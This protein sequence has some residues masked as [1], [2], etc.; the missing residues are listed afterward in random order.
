L[1]LQAWKTAERR[2]AAA[3]GGQRHIRFDRTESACDVDHDLLSVECKY[4]KRLPTLVKAAM[5]QAERYSDGAKI[6]AAVLFERGQRGGFVVLRLADFAE[7]F[8]EFR[9]LHVTEEIP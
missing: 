4:R 8:G 3:L 9:S 7:L 2:A 1:T 5:A 6:P